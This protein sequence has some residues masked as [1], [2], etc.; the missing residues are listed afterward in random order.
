MDRSVFVTLDWATV[1]PK[2][3]GAVFAGLGEG[4]LPNPY[5]TSKDLQAELP[6]R[7]FAGVVCVRD[8]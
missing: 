6:R 8:D 1:D 4:L 7:F 2:D 5:W 3:G